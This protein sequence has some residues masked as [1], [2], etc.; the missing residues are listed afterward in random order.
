MSSQDQESKM[1]VADQAN[2]VEVEAE[3]TESEGEGDE[4]EP[5]EETKPIPSESSS[6]GLLG[7][8]KGDREKSNILERWRTG[9]KG[10]PTKLP[11]FD[12]PSLRALG[13]ST[14][15]TQVLGSGILLAHP[16]SNDDE[17]EDNELSETD[18]NGEGSYGVLAPG[19]PD[20]TP[21]AKPRAI[22][23]RPIDEQVSILKEGFLALAA[24]LNEHEDRMSVVEDRLAHVEGSFRSLQ[25]FIDQKQH[26]V[27][28]EMITHKGEI[29]A[30]T[31]AHAT[32]QAEL[33]I[34][35]GCIDEMKEGLKMTKKDMIKRVSKSQPV[36][37]A[38]R[39]RSSPAAAPEGPTAQARGAPRSERPPAHRRSRQSDELA[40]HEVL[41]FHKDMKPASANLNRILAEHVD[42]LRDHHHIT[43]IGDLNYRFNH[44]PQVMLTLIV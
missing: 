7:Q 19:S 23:P 25:Q 37:V 30:L 29:R 10:D 15:T 9:D 18:E 3:P 12:S 13:K 24:N 32:I 11:N 38:R 6:Y 4:S 8:P 33:S 26:S 5:T 2:E 21:Q 16:P 34:V 42:F 14:K 27:S 35:T 36:K 28:D 41:F 22:D 1:A 17:E 40:T 39:T 44:S 20:K 31:A 43:H